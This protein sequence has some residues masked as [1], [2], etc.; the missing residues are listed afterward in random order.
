MGSGHLSKRQSEFSATYKT[1][2]LGLCRNK[3][4]NI[5]VLG[6]IVSCKDIVSLVAL[7][8]NL[9]VPRKKAQPA[10]FQLNISTQVRSCCDEPYQRYAVTQ[11]PGWQR[12]LPSVTVASQP[13]RPRPAAGIMILLPSHSPG[14]T[15]GITQW[16]QLNGKGVKPME[17]REQPPVLL[18]QTLGCRGQIRVRH[19][20]W[21]DCCT[22]AVWQSSFTSG[23]DES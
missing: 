19:K 14:P 3:T 6:Q 21:E 22:E 20:N 5:A 23:T 17:L 12:F 2:I 4:Q 10:P 13:T 15:A 8:Y 18:P 9:L 7:L 1:E 16:G 11:L